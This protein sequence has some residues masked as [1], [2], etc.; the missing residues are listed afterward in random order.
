MGLRAWLRRKP[1]AP[2]PRYNLCP[3]CPRLSGGE[4]GNALATI[5]TRDDFVWCMRCGA[6]Y[7]PAHRSW[8][9]PDSSLLGE[10]RL[11]GKHG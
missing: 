7:H 9:M 5:P 1:A 11:P 10:Y 3:Y 4:L 6:F 2:K 8:L